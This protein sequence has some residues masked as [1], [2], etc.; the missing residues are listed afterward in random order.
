MFER[1]MSEAEDTLSSKDLDDDYDENSDEE[2]D[3]EPKKKGGVRFGDEKQDEGEEVDEFQDAMEE[4]HEE[5]SSVD[6]ATAEVEMTENLN[7]A[8]KNLAD[9]LSEEEE[10]EDSHLIETPPT[11][12]EHLWNIGGP[13]LG[14]MVV[15]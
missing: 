4:E 1:D 9:D 7:T 13:L 15:M 11:F 3:E 6:K 12:S 5:L 10:E 14:A 8:T 2:E